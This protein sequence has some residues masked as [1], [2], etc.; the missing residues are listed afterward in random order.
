MDSKAVSQINFDYNGKHYCLEYTR[1]TVKIMESW[2]FNPNDVADKPAIRL[3]QLWR[4][5]F[6]AN[7]RNKISDAVI[8]KL[9]DQM[10]N[11]A[12]LMDALRDMVIE[13]Y[14]SLLP[15]DDE[16]DSGNVEWTT[17]Q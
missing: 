5:A 8:G 16:D 6:L 14:T 7:H 3:E 1:D 2:G 4:G 11:K 10:K 15:D 12:A 17:V 13:T 9:Y